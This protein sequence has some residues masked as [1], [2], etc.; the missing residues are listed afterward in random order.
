MPQCSSQFGEVGGGGSLT[1]SGDTCVSTFWGNK[2]ARW[3]EGQLPYRECSS[4]RPEAVIK[5]APPATGRVV[6]SPEP[7][8]D[9]K[10][11]TELVLQGR[12]SKRAPGFLQ[13]VVLPERNMKVSSRS[14]THARRK[15]RLGEGT[16]LSML[17]KV[18]ISERAQFKVIGQRV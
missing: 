17:A 16:F 10:S 8:E 11:G 15:A 6:V 9:E 18:H 7:T 3:G 4:C 2:A 5:P 12:K 14:P 13:G 1:A